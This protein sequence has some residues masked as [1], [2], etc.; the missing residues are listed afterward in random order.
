MMPKA[1]HRQLPAQDPELHPHSGEQDL[2]KE[3]ARLRDLL[4]WVAPRIRRRNANGMESDSLCL[5]CVMGIP[6]FKRQPCRHAEIFALAK[7][8]RP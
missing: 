7:E 8:N 1:A 6:E 5:L 2:E 4:A 3:N